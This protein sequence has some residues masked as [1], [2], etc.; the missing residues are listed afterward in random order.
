M[1]RRTTCQRLATLLVTGFLAVSA[2]P[3]ALAQERQPNF[4][5]QP[6][7]LISQEDV[8][9]T[10]GDATP[11]PDTLSP[12]APMTTEEVAASAAS[13]QIGSEKLVSV[14]VKLDVD[15]L[16][17]YSGGVPGLPATSPVATGAPALDVTTPESR[18]YLDYVS[19]QIDSFENSSKRTLS[20]A[21]II[22]R[23]DVIVGGVSMVVPADEVAALAGLPGVE[24]I[25]PDILEQPQTETSPQFIGVATIWS[26]LWDV[27][28]GYSK[29]GEGVVVGV[30]DSGIWPEHV[31]V[32][33]PDPFGRPFPAPPA[34]PD[35]DR[36]CE[37]SGGS[38]PGDPFTCNNKLIG[39]DRFMAT[40]DAVIGLLPG[41]FTTARDDNGHGSHTATTAAGNGGV[42]ATIFGVDRGI[43][44]GVAPRAH[45]MVYKVCGNSGCFTTDSVAAV[46]EAIQDG[47]HV[48]NFS[49]SGGNN[50]Y[51]DIVSLAFLDAYNAGVF[52]AASAGN[53]GPAAE[54][55]SHR[56]PWVTTVAAST[57]DR[58]FVSTLTLGASGGAS[59]TL[60]GA[61]VT[62][63]LATPTPVVFS[64]EI[65]GD[66]QCN[67]DFPAGAAAGKVVICQRGGTGRVSK[68]DRVLRAGGVG[69]ILY[70][71]PPLR[72]GVNT[73]NHFVPTVHLE[74]DAAAQLLAFMTANT[75]EVASF[76]LSSARP[77]QGDV[78]TSFSSRGGPAQ[79]LGVNKP[80]VTAPGIQI[81]AGHAPQ[82]VDVAGGPNGEQFQAIAGT[83]MS[84][85]HVAGAA[86]LLKALEPSWTPGQIKSALMT[87]ASAEG[88]VKEDGVTP[89]TP[90]D[91]G[92]G[93]I[94][95]GKAWFPSFTMSETGANFIAY[96]DE[97]WQANLPSLFVPVMPGL[98]TVQRTAQDVTGYPSFFNSQL[99]F[100]A[101]QPSD[102]SV[103]VPDGFV[104][105]ASGSYS[106]SITVDA[107]DVPIGQ[108]RHATV[109]FVESDGATARFPISFVRA[110][111]VVQITKSCDPATIALGQ[112]TTCSVTM[113]NNSYSPVDAAM[114]DELPAQLQLV[115]GS[116]TRGTVSGNGVQFRG[117]LPGRIAPTVSVSRA[118]TNGYLSLSTLGAPPNVTMADE[119]I[120]NI[121]TA[122]P[123]IY[124]GE[125]YTRIAMTSNG[126]A[127]V[128]GGTASDLDFINR[129]FPNPARPNNTLAPFWTDLDGSK[130]GQYYAYTLCDGTCAVATNNRWQVLEWRN[131]PNYSNAAQVNSFQIWVGLNGVE[132]I[133]FA[134]G[135]VLT[136]GDAG[137]L[138]VGAEN[139]LGTS[140]D[141]IYSN[142][143]SGPV[144]GTAPTA[145]GN[146]VIVTS[147]PGVPPT[148]VTVTFQATGVQVGS[149]VNY[150]EMT[151]TAFFG[152]NIARFSGAVTP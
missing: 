121:T 5:V 14:F 127:V 104:I 68:S 51:S 1:I 19:Q 74:S 67:T 64:T 102:F 118:T 111:P 117:S 132:D 134:Y 3:L 17:A 66:V 143:G 119:T 4:D 55:V 133:S 40:Y 151:S 80:D 90:F 125:S 31:S 72:Q 78:I 89:F 76:M 57:A 20:S 87:T 61:S 13:V 32:S 23:F 97:L 21:T 112:T 98:V 37:F 144:I 130:G 128:G 33:D 27:I 29:A 35:G 77:G 142:D 73:D 53:S 81:L 39:A 109:L 12:A 137:L 7:T 145:N 150:A 52:V 41:E 69:M 148:P 107:R 95:L 83:S 94:D 100:P 18:R 123:F 75:G 50:P 140:G 120:V 85:P 99:E 110:Q 122:R 8:V 15:S 82:H 36:A 11:S 63:A 16:A 34:A 131:A 49:I 38:N 115:P 48:I 65:G 42:Q 96:R 54:T 6:A 108:V 56:E 24:A 149:Y 26:L 2:A 22:H 93:R 86:A 92:S 9:T 47:V 124:G 43:V 139:L 84:S 152:T 30:L 88:L 70:N 129:D 71:N 135:P 116:L 60:E 103:S 114:R 44:S 79:P 58:Q 136:T 113:T 141:N 101:G 59:L 45:L 28:G 147:V 62:A 146:D 126:Y 138:T 46:Q 105:P 25:Y 106:F 91:A 10:K